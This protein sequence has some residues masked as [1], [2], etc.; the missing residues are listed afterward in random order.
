MC[1][2]IS[3]L[4]SFTS[5]TINS[6]IRSVSDYEFRGLGSLPVMV[7]RVEVFLVLCGTLVPISFLWTLINCMRQTSFALGNFSNLFTLR[8]VT[9][10]FQLYLSIAV[11]SSIGKVFDSESKGPGISPSPECVMYLIFVSISFI[12]LTLDR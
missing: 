4:H 9:F 3:L 5:T 10:Q 12:F 1:D 2:S 6:T 8:N 11:N 7:I